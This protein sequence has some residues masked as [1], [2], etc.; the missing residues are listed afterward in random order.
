MEEHEADRPPGLQQRPQAVIHR[1]VTQVPGDRP[2]LEEGVVEGVVE[3]L[4]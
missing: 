2:H 3:G 1:V 4:V